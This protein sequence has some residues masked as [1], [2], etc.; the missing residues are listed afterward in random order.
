MTPGNALRDWFD[1]EQPIVGMVHLPPLPGA[2]AFEG[3]RE[4]VRTRALEDAR[5]LEAGGVDGIVLENFGDAPFYPDDVPNHVVAELTA[6]ATALTDAVEVPVG[7][8][9]LRNDAAAALSV[10]A[11]ADAQFVRVNVHVG[12]A[13]TDQGI[14]EGRAHETL[15]LRDR[16][17]TDV[18]IFA[19][20]HVKHATQIGANA[21]GRA[22]LET[23]ERGK[24]DAVI[25]SGPGTGVET[26]VE[27]IR[28]VTDIL[29]EHGHD[30]TPV[31][32]G[33]GV[34][35]ETVADCFE[36]GADGL[37]VGTALKRDGVTT[38]PVSGDRVET[39][40][41]AVREASSSD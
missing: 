1:T 10:A 20:V 21:I 13:A 7:I 23:V 5:R 38:N 18:G 22:V 29:T 31:F 41:A 34:T 39:L 33:S 3:D 37:I 16:L 40:V 28:R 11:A 4:T 2:P 17:E 14:L 24:A 27:D 25:V 35:S 30:T 36:A 12:T 9:V 8:N 6:I 15:R 19:D 32:V 26:D